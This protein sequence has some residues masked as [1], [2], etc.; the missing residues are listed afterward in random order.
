MLV[1]HAINDDSIAI[2]V[3][4]ENITSVVLDLEFLLDRL[5]V[6]LLLRSDDR[7]EV[8][9]AITTGLILEVLEFFAKVTCFLAKLDEGVVSLRFRH[10]VLRDEEVTRVSQYSGVSAESGTRLRVRPSGRPSYATPRGRI[11]RAV[12]VTVSSPSAVAMPCDYCYNFLNRRVGVVGLSH[13]SH[14]FVA[15]CMRVRVTLPCIM[16]AELI[17]DAVGSIGNGPGLPLE[18]PQPTTRFL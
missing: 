11:S 2:L 14:H 10:V 15:Q 1:G 4:V 7:V 9:G 17:G 18:V 8:W 5:V 6:R 16:P 3:H 12:R 13:S